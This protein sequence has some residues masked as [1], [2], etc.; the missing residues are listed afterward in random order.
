MGFPLAI[1]APQ[2]G[3]RSETFIRRH[4]EDIVPEKTVVIAETAA[5]PY[6]GYWD[7]KCPKLILDSF[8]LA[9]HKNFL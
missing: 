8:P 5:R 7:V 4:M 9:F 3:A 2:I 6:A 1:I